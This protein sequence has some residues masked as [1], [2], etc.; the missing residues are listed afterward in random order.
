MP[1]NTLKVLSSRIAIVLFQ[2]GHFAIIQAKEVTPF[3]S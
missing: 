3:Q 1:V 2:H